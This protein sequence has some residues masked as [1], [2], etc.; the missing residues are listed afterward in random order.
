MNERLLFTM[1]E[2]SVVGKWLQL[3][4]DVH[5]SIALGLLASGTYEVKLGSSSQ[6]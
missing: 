1:K 3:E 5:I 2:G 4:V 6:R